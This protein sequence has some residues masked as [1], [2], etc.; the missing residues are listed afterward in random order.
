VARTTTEPL[1][2]A[3][4]DTPAVR[5]PFDW[6]RGLSFM[7]SD[8]AGLYPH[9]LAR[10]AL[11][12]DLTFRDQDRLRR[13]NERALTYLVARGSSGPPAEWRS[14]ASDCMYTLLQLL[15]AP[16]RKRM[17]ERLGRGLTS[18]AATERDLPA[19]AALVERHEGPE[20]AAIAAH[21]LTRQLHNV[22]VIR[23]AA[24]APA[25]LFATV[26][27]ERLSD[28]DRRIDPAVAAALAHLERR[29]PLP[30]GR[31][32]S[33]VRFWMARDGYQDPSPVQALCASLVNQHH[34]ARPQLGYSFLPFAEP[35]RH[36]ELTTLGS[37]VRAPDL[38]FDVGGRRYGMFMHDWRRTPPLKFLA[39]LV[40][41]GESL[42]DDD[43]PL[44]DAERFADGVRLA[45]RHLHDARALADNP[46][47][48]ARVVL[49]RVAAGAPFDAHAEA[50]RALVTGAVA[51]LDGTPRNR[52]LR[53]ALEVTFV[54]AVGTQEEAA[55]ALDL[56][57]STYRRHL[58]EGIAAVVDGLW[59]MESGS[60]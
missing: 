42:R 13:L 2:A 25:G 41:T 1:L 34:V 3:L 20:S 23:D 14:S 48:H 24:A 50:L 18:E 56:P 44:L 30:P 10:K 11:V 35:D 5:A 45:L 7:Q 58:T 4:L 49:A 55:E 16:L 36:Q 43:P 37:F 8:R 40:R 19:L 47:L 46:L 22:T 39:H 27:L 60:D 29:A 26:A 38:D 52:K 54:S 31:T 59:R 32:A 53:E 21:W 33:M 51:A 12:A 6:L 17:S 15:P 9:D 57:F 28:A